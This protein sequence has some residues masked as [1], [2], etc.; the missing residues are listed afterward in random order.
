MKSRVLVTDGEQRA[1]L[2]IVRSLGQAGYA[3]F[4][5]ATRTPSLAG[6]SR[7]AMNEHAVPD[8]LSHPLAYVDTLVEIAGRES[9]GLILPV[10]EASLLAVLSARERFS[11]LSLP[12]S[13]LETFRRVSDKQLVLDT[14]R[15]VGVAVPEQVV[16]ES[17]EAAAALSVADL[18]YPLVLKPA[19]SVSGTGMARGK[20]SV[21]HIAG[22]D[23]LRAALMAVSPQAFPILLQQRIVGPGVGIFLLDWHGHSRAIFSHRR[24]REKP[25][26]GGVSV[27]RE[28]ISADPWLVERS[29]LLLNRLGFEG[30]AMVEYKLDG[31]S[32]RP[33]LMEINGRFWGSL[34]L[35]IDSGVDFPRILADLALGG[36]V[37]PAPMY[38]VGVR[39]R[40]WWGDVDQLIARLT[41][42][43][44][45]L[46]LPP[47]EPGRLQSLLNFLAMWRLG[48]RN[49]VLR[50][51][52]PQPFVRET[53]DWFRWR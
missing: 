47:G 14:A 29:R 15:S 25:P 37:G 51:S 45:E 1:A 40:W 13:D 46:A 28:S 24:L 39:S 17:P 21:S 23:A 20:Y 4:V 53:L 33:Y 32:G 49:E 9:V 50:L 38:K 19:R 48:D 6:A 3:V 2:A 44:S 35:A 31:E 11:G 16:V 5:A 22:Q 36:V 7:W 27:Y 30:V 8:S 52:D 41:R 18:S 34:Q 26:S 42:S 12:F 10:T 43:S